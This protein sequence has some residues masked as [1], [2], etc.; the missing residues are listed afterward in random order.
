MSD[1]KFP[2]SRRITKDSVAQKRVENDT[3]ERLSPFAKGDMNANIAEKYV[4]TILPVSKE[5]DEKMKPPTALAQYVVQQTATNIMDNENILQLL[6][7][8]ELAMQVLISSILAPNN[9]MT[10]ELNYV[11]D[12]DD[13]GDLKAP[14][15][16]GQRILRQRL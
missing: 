6:P 2:F 5:K 3:G 13:L 14:L 16:E 9:M 1:N 15:V 8:M 7:D 12:A 10:C 11:C 4:H